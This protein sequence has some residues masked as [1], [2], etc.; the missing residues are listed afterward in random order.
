M[1]RATPPSPSSLKHLLL[2]IGWNPILPEQHQGQHISMPIVH[3]REIA[4]LSNMAHGSIFGHPGST[5]YLFTGKT[6]PMSLDH[7]SQSNAAILICQ[8]SRP[9]RRETLLYLECSVGVLCHQKLAWCCGFDGFSWLCQ[10]HVALQGT[11]QKS[12]AMDWK[13]WWPPCTLAPHTQGC[14]AK[15]ILE[16]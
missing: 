14:P 11:S 7:A 15:P 8:H 5:K 10:Y 13:E 4:S 9:P 1:H 2:E 3:A 6:K 12:L 16:G